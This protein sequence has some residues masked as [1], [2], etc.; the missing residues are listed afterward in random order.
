RHTRSKRDW[1]SDVCSSDLALSQCI[2]SLAQGAARQAPPQ[3]FCQLAETFSGEIERI[4]H[5]HARTFPACALDS[6]A[7]ALLLLSDENA[8]K[9]GRASCRERV[10][11]R[12]VE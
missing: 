10:S 11:R 2:V 4:A 1:S 3:R 12:V 7:E 8:L 5:L 9:I 6:G